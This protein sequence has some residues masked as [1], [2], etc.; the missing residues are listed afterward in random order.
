MKSFNEKNLKI[1]HLNSQLS[2]GGGL[3]RIIV[4]LMLNNDDVENYLCIINDKWSN[5]FINLFNEKSFLLCNRREGTKNIWINLITYYKIIRF[6]K[7]NKI[8]VI[9]CHDTM[10]LKMAY[11][12][13]KIFKLKVV[14]TVHD[15]TSFNKKIAK[16]SID[17]YVA[18]S[19][20]VYKTIIKYIEKEKIEINY[21][22]VNLKKFCNSFNKKED[23]K[24][25]NI[26]CVARLVPEL[27][28]QDILIKALDNLKKIHKFDKF[29][30]SFAGSIS[31]DKSFK[32]LNNL[33][34]KYN[35]QTNIKFLGNVERIEEL[36]NMTD[37]LI[38]PSRK[39][40]FGLVVVEALASGCIVIVSKLEGPLEIVKETEE[41]GLHFE[42][43]NFKELSEKLYQVINNNN[44]REKYLD[45]KKI[46]S[47]IQE[48]SL[49]EM[50]ARYNVIYRSV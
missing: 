21:N 34:Q 7:K 35:L 22:G 28:G 5:Q 17:K 39:E 37:I 33:V 6:I 43:G 46:S 49:D 12:L 30:C 9:H 13:K 31:D 36:Y 50:I 42:V 24:L 11:F 15:T 18:I 26:A 29:Q 40:G 32:Y 8:R 48:Y 4:D 2:F 47:Y 20:A 10:S 38:L 41:Y 3:E 14:Y 23:S 19:H 44:L 25:L 27:K 16:Y 1:L 45:Y